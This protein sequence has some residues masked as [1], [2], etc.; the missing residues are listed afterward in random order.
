MQVQ[1]QNVKRL[2]AVDSSVRGTSAVA[3]SQSRLKKL[4][5]GWSVLFLASSMLAMAPAL[6]APPPHAQGKGPP[7]H[8]QGKEAFSHGHGKGSAHHR[9]HHS[10][11][12]AER[13]RS[14]RDAEYHRSHRDAQY[15]HRHRHSSW[16]AERRMRNPSG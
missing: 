11:P 10:H 2:V 6:S 9:G 7:P 16:Y 13:H 8:A 5:W 14:D 1:S 4:R 3:V 12:S 15:H